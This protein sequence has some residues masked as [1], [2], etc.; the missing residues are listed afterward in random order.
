[1]I[2]AKYNIHGQAP[3][4]AGL[5]GVTDFEQVARKIVDGDFDVGY[6]R[7]YKPYTGTA[8]RTPRYS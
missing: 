8:Q 5:A 1:V 7:E 4:S 2:V 6:G 3:S